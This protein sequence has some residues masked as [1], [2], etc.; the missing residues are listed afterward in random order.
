M[1]E[2]KKWEFVFPANASKK[3]MREAVETFAEFY[4]S[5][6]VGEYSTDK[7]FNM[8][9]QVFGHPRFADGEVISTSDIIAI[10]RDEKEEK[11]DLFSG[12][13]SLDEVANYVESD[14]LYAKT[15]SGSK[16][17]LNKQMGANMFLYLGTAIHGAC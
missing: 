1:A 15:E 16:Y 9:G 4:Q 5:G 14:P 13:Y 7:K 2:L 3:D 17:Y 12:K 11:P 8:T 6:K 10:G